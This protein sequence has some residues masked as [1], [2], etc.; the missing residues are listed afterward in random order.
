ME[1]IKKCRKCYK[2]LTE[3]NWNKSY[4]SSHDY[5]CKKC[6]KKSKIN[7]RKPCSKNCKICNQK[8]NCRRY[9]Q[10]DIFLQK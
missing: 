10:K 1:K 3:K 5:I 8:Y 9:I 6:K 4:K 2:I 7:Y